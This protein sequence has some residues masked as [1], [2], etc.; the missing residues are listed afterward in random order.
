MTPSR[1]ERE[2][3]VKLTDAQ[4]IDAAIDE[5]AAAMKRRMRSK[6]KQGWGGWNHGEM[7]R[8]LLERMLTNAATAFS[9]AD[10]K[11]LIDTANFAMMVRRLK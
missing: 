2:A 10:E 8:D 7:K 9:S 1:D 11:S 3:L 6:R 4:K 5:F